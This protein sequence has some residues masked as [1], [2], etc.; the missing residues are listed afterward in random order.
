M[1]PFTLSIETD[2]GT[3]RHG[4]HLG[5]IE[6]LAR[7]LAEEICLKRRPQRGTRIV[8]VALC[9][10]ESIVDVFDGKDWSNAL[11]SKF[12]EEAA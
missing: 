11:L 6:R 5:T 12:A 4:F 8:T 1:Q 2:A 9:R 7:E 3:Y 10:F